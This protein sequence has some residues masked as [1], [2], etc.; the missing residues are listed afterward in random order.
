MLLQRALGRAVCPALSRPALP[1]APGE[2][3]VGVVVMCPV[4]GGVLA[5]DSEVL[6]DAMG[7]MPTASMALRFVL[8]NPNVSCACSGMSTI[9]MLEENVRTVKEF[10]PEATSFEEMC[11]G[12]D[13]LHSALG[14]AF[15]TGCRY[16]QPCPQGVNISRYM[17]LYNSWKAFGLTDGVREA[18]A[19]FPDEWRASNCNECGRCEK[20]CP[21]S[22][23]IRERL[24]EMQALET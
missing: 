11:E 16:C 12:V 15:C 6:R 18:L 19:G 4:G 24:K 10:D 20:Q 9:E 13:R 17:Q 2:L 8:S 14:D 5:C 22:I 7:D 23:P 21:N 1:L 3:G